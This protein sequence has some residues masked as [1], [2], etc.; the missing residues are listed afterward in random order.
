M[1]NETTDNTM[2]AESSHNVDEEVKVMRTVNSHAA[3]SNQHKGSM[4][5]RFVPPLRVDKV[6][7]AYGA[8][9]MPNLPIA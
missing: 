3:F 6:K 9:P 5:N 4:T 2:I 8:Q 7:Q 1:I